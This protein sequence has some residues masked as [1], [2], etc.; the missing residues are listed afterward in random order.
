VIRIETIPP[1]PPVPPVPEPMM[2]WLNVVRQMLGLERMR[3]PTLLNSWVGAG[4][5]YAAAGYWKQLGVVR[6]TGRVTAGTGAI[7][8]LPRGFRPG[9]TVRFAVEGDGGPTVVEVKTDGTVAG[10]GSAT[11]SVSLDGINFRAEG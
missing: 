8:A 9:A 6:L 1:V 7:L 11:V 5:P 3:T 10:V 4:S 2:N